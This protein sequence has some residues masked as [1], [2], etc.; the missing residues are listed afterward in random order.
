M[1]PAEAQVFERVT[2]ELPAT[3]LESDEKRVGLHTP[4]DN[5]IAARSAPGPP[6]FLF[7]S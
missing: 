6:Q 3:R 2:D 1:V 5:A 4:I 7:S